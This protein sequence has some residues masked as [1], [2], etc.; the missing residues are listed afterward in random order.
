MLSRTAQER[1]SL[2]ASAEQ[3]DRLHRHEAQREVAL[4]QRER[5]RVS[6]DGLET[7]LLSAFAQRPEQHVAAVERRDRVS[8]PRELQ[9]H[10]AAAGADVEHATA[11]ALRELAPERQVGAVAAAL[12]VVPDDLLRKP[13]RL[14][15]AHDHELLSLSARDEQLAQRQHR[16]VRR[17]RV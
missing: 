15:V 17:Q 10:T 7:G 12:E 5:A 14:A 1:D 3:L 9:R 8:G 13:R 2:L 11:A 16:R 6:A 4:G